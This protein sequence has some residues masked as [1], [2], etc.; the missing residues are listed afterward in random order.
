MQGVGAQQMQASQGF[1]QQPFRPYGYASLPGQFPGSFLASGQLPREGANPGP[2][3]ASPCHFTYPQG[4]SQQMGLP[5]HAMYQ[6][7]L[8]YL[9]Q[10]LDPTQIPLGYFGPPSSYPLQQMTPGLWPQIRPNAQSAGTAAVPHLSGPPSQVDTHTFRGRD[11]QSFLPKPLPIQS[12]QHAFK[13][14]CW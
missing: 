13:K 3:V 4:L 7:A 5:L 10:P 1:P 2:P 8:P 12:G 6:Q 9:Q 11:Q 14:N